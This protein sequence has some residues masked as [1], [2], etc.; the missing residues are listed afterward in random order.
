MRICGCHAAAPPRFRR[1]RA[2]AQERDNIQ[3]AAAHGAPYA[4]RCAPIRAG[5][6][7]TASPLS[8][9]VPTFVGT[10]FNKRWKMRYVLYAAAS[11]KCRD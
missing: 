1:R 6:R 11:T 10:G 9:K 2:S 3:V 5:N 7:R 4:T 8:D